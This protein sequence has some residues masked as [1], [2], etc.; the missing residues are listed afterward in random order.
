MPSDLVVDEFIMLAIF[1]LVVAA[2]VLSI[3][4]AEKNNVLG[5]NARSGGLCPSNPTISQDLLFLFCNVIEKEANTGCITKLI[6]SVI[7]DTYQS[8][9]GLS[10]TGL[11]GINIINMGSQILT[12]GKVDATVVYGCPSPSQ[13]DPNPC[14]GGKTSYTINGV[15]NTYI[16]D[17][18][19]FNA[20][21]TTLRCSWGSPL[22]VGIF[23]DAPACPVGVTCVPL[24]VTLGGSTYELTL[25]ASVILHMILTA[26]DCATGEVTISQLEIEITALSATSTD[27]QGSIAT[28]INDN[29]DI[30][31]GE[32][33]GII[34][35]ALN[36]YVGQA[37]DLSAEQIAVNIIC[38]T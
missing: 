18:H 38:Q 26:T 6:S 13:I 28:L 29:Q 15:S 8:S 34:N 36:T 21:D 37:F 5:E 27:P 4:A 24:Q 25:S 9:L 7:P 14:C 35:P 3:L 22:P 19:A 31:V 1:G 17:S 2:L 32:L 12:P 11:E 10:I 30:I 20:I 16:D 33:N 23:S